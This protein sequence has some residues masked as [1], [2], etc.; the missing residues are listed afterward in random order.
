MANSKKTVTARSDQKLLRKNLEEKLVSIRETVSRLIDNP[1]LLKDEMLRIYQ[2]S[3]RRG[4]SLDFGLVLKSIDLAIEIHHGQYRD[5]MLEYL[6]HPLEVGYVLAET[7]ADEITVAAGILHDG[8]EHKKR[9]LDVVRT[10]L[11]TISLE[12]K[13][14]MSPAREAHLI[15]KG[16]VRGGE[17][18]RLIESYLLPHGQAVYAIVDAVTPPKYYPFGR[19]PKTQ[20]EKKKAAARRVVYRMRKDPKKRAYLVKA[21]DRLVNLLTLDGLKDKPAKSAEE[22]KR[23]ILEDTMNN[24][25]PLAEETDKIYKK[26][27]S[28]LLLAPYLR[29]IVRMYK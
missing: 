23:I 22:R 16:Y 11:E 24:I 13:G 5:S 9:N 14:S 7:G 17:I 19:S 29:D 3:G 2:S 20:S 4:N 8:E 27:G 15:A 12:N 18:K 25:I 26:I 10:L 28:G 6:A 1:E 21:A